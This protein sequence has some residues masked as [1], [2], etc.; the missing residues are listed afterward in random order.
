MT[1]IKS[2]SVGNGDMFYIDHSSDNFTIIDCC[3]NDDDDDTI[4]DEIAEL[5]ANSGIARF[6][7]TH[8]DEDHLRGLARLDD[9]INI[10]NFY[11]VKNDATKEDES[12]SFIRYCKLRDSTKAFYIEKDCSRRWMN[13]SSD[14]RSSSGITI[15]WPDRDN[16]HFKEALEDANAGGSPNNIS[17]VIQYMRK[18]MKRAV[19]LWMGDLETDFMTNIES[20]LNLSKV[21]L[22]FAPHHGRASGKVPATMLEKLSPQIVIIGEAPSEHLDYYEGFDTITQNSAGDLVFECHDDEIDIFSSLDYEVDFLLDKGRSLA[23]H[24]YVGTLRSLA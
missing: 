9:R 12:D 2:H 23:G 11:C 10:L 5:D 18:G 15:L 14:A 8:P 4:L 22:L 24:Y 17:A 1:T 13:Q 21:C 3:L 20:A 19:A 6:I 16:E 7:S